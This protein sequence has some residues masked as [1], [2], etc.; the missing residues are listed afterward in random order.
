MVSK[1]TVTALAVAAALAMTGCSH[2]IKGANEPRESATAASPSASAATSAAATVTQS[3]EHPP[4]AVGVGEC[5]DVDRSGVG[6]RFSAVVSCEEAHDG[7]AFLAVTVDDR[8]LVQ[9]ADD[10]T[11]ELR[12]ALRDPTRGRTYALESPMGY[13]YNQSV[14]N[15][16]D[17]VLCVYV[18]AEPEE[19]SIED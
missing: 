3:T 10:C 15:P 8:T 19:G 16:G 9:V 2:E 1:T 11:A 18:F 5:V 7:E 12:S 13:V 17:E 4:I 14:V 6:I